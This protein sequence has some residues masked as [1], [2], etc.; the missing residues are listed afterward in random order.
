MPHR[1]VY[2]QSIPNNQNAESIRHLGKL[3]GKR[4]IIVP[5]FNT[6]KLTYLKTFVTTLAYLLAGH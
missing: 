1:S 6:S 5:G 2:K 4:G 3:M